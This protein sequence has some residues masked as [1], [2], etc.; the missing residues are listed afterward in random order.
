MG[1]RLV[2]EQKLPTA[3]GRNGLP[4]GLSSKEST[5]NAGDTGDVGSIPGSGRSPGGGSGNQLQYSCQNNPWGHKSET[6]EHACRKGVGGE[7][8]AMELRSKGK[9]IKQLVAEGWEK[10]HAP[11]R[12]SSSP[13][14]YWEEIFH[15]FEWSP[16]M[17]A[18]PCTPA[19]VPSISVTTV[20]TLC[21]GVRAGWRQRA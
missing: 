2:V 13:S 5:C 19:D 7:K 20:K 1:L 4:Q 21:R 10:F 12:S 18:E 15:W 9:R 16:S 11:T 3:Q 17:L 14:V 6:T 8:G